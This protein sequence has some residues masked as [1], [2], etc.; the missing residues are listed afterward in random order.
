[1]FSVVRSTLSKQDTMSASKIHLTS[2]RSTIRFRVRTASWAAR[3]GPGGYTSCESEGEYIPDN[4]PMSAPLLDHPSYSLPRESPIQP[5]TITPVRTEPKSES[6]QFS[7]ISVLF[8]RRCFVIM[9]VLTIVIV[10]VKILFLTKRGSLFHLTNTLRIENS[11]GIVH[12]SSCCSNF[13]NF[14]RCCSI[15]N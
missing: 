2:P 15:C 9:P 8:F 4:R 14:H 12:V 5:D 10:L 11:L 1:M 3:A 7:L 13:F 6:S